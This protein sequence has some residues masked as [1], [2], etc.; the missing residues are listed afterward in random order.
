MYYT[1]QLD[2]IGKKRPPVGIDGIDKV[3]LKSNEASLCLIL[4]VLSAQ[5]WQQLL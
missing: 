5:L 4:I 3:I 1:I 2:T